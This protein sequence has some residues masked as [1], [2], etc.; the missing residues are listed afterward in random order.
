MAYVGGDDDPPVV[1]GS[2]RRHV[3]KRLE[4]LNEFGIAIDDPCQCAIRALFTVPYIVLE[5]VRLGESNCRTAIR[6]KAAIRLLLEST[7]NHAA[8]DRKREQRRSPANRLA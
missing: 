3:C 2:R 1:L 8:N 5:G 7:E 6:H 4:P